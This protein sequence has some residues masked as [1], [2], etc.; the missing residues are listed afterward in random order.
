M[1][2]MKLTSSR[3]VFSLFA[4]FWSVWAHGEELYFI[5]AHSQVDHNIELESVIVLMGE[6][7]VK[8]T[9]LAARSQRKSKEIADL[10]EAYPEQ[11]VASVR[12]KNK[13]YKRNTNK[14]YKN[15]TK[16]LNSGRFKAMAEVLLYHA[17]KGSLADEVVVFPDDDR[18][19]AAFE[20]ARKHGWP[21][22][23]HIEFASLSGNQRK[24]YFTALESFIEQ[25]HDHPIVLIHM[26]QLDVSNVKMLIDKYTNI[27]FLISHT[28]PIAVGRSNQPWVNMFKNDALA[29]EWEALLVA[30]HKRFIFA[31]D[32]VWPEHWRNGYKE[33][34]Q[35]WRIALSKLPPDVANAVAH[36]NAES[37]W[38]L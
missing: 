3:L 6:A 19:K 26:G 11:I 10:A 33:Q 13:Y 32:N 28:N 21:F 12:T 22:I 37:L 38:K 5:D 27:Y 14:Y 16:Q 9:I 35:L 29:P 34:V 2:L 4:I 17:Q 31:L 36:R 7:G 15:L 25:H 8:K 23:L 20:G 1:D 18:V 30:R 24:K